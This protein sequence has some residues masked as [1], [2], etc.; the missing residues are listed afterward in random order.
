[1]LSTRRRRIYKAFADAIE[2]Y[3]D[4]LGVYFA[5]QSAFA[6][7][8]NQDRGIIVYPVQ[9]SFVRREKFGEIR[10]LQ[11]SVA[12]F[13]RLGQFQQFENVSIEINR[14]ARSQSVQA[15]TLDQTEQEIRWEIVDPDLHVMTMTYRF[16][17]LDTLAR[18]VTW[19]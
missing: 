16:E 17:Y 4:G 12:Y 7:P 2:R 6:I 5:E 14:L 19:Q 3:A 11:V 18:D 8:S 9:D 15:L 10:F 13:E 1:M